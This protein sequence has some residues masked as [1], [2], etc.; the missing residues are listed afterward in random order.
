MAVIGQNGETI[1]LNGGDPEIGIKTLN[2]T[3][4]NFHGDDDDQSVEK[5]EKWLTF[6]FYVLF[7]PE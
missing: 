7:K 5:Q 6:Y 2:V 1:M 4:Y 3:Q